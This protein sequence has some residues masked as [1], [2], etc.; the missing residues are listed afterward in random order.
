[1]AE[2]GTFDPLRPRLSVAGLPDITVADIFVTN[3]FEKKFVALIVMDKEGEIM[4]LAL[5]DQCLDHSRIPEDAEVGV[6][7]SYVLDSARRCLL[8]LK[9]AAIKTIE[10]KH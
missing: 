4:F 8:V 9:Q 5:V 3:I 1:M 10:K 7:S 2:G 6:K